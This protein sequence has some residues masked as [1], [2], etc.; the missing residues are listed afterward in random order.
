[1]TGP[2][3]RRRGSRLPLMLWLIPAI[4]VLLVAA[5]PLAMV[6][7]KKTMTHDDDRPAGDTDHTVGNVDRREGSSS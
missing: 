4:A 1:M 6:A 7:I 3:R 5:R 2:F